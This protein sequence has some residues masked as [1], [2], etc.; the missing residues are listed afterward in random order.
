MDHVLANCR[1]TPLTR[2]RF[3]E[4]LQEDLET[5]SLEAGAL[6]DREALKAAAAVAADPYC[7]RDPKGGR[8]R[9]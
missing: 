5:L 1:L 7:A 9:S 8:S 6:S 4:T 2:D 3:L